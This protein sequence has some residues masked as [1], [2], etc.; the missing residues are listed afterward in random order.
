MIH[1]SLV[2]ASWNE[3]VLEIDVYPYPLVVYVYMTSTVL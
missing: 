2:E 1:C 3:I